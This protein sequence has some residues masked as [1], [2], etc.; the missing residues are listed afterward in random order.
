MRKGYVAIAHYMYVH[1]CFIWCKFYHVQQLPETQNPITRSLFHSRQHK[2]SASWR[3]IRI[4]GAL[5]VGQKKGSSL[6]DLEDGAQ[7]RKKVQLGTP[8]TRSISIYSSRSPM[9]QR[10]GFWS[11]GTRIITSLHLLVH[12]MAVPWWFMSKGKT[13]RWICFQF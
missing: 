3:P 2:F 6:V 4:D 11:S 7:T 1:T 10:S 5:K 8:A 12:Q 9:K 13:R